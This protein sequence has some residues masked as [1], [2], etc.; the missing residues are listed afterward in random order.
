LKTISSN[1]KLRLRQL[2]WEILR[3]NSLK[4]K[5][6]VCALNAYMSVCPPRGRGLRKNMDLQFVVAEYKETIETEARESTVSRSKFFW[7]EQ[8]YRWAES[9][10]GNMLQPAEARA[11]W[12]MWLEDD[13]IKKDNLGPKKAP[14]RIAV[15][16][17]E[18]VHESA[19]SLLTRKI[20]EFKHKGVK[21]PNAAQCAQVREGVMGSHQ[22]IGGAQV[23]REAISDFMGKAMAKADGSTTSQLQKGINFGNVDVALDIKGLVEK[24]A[25]TPAATAMA[26]SA[27]HPSGNPPPTKKLKA[28][29][30]REESVSKALTAWRLSIA[31]LGKSC[32]EHIKSMSKLTADYKHI[33][34]GTSC[35]REHLI[36]KPSLL[37]LAGRLDA[38]QLVCLQGEENGSLADEDLTKAKEKLKVYLDA[39]KNPQSNLTPASAPINK[40][41]DLKVLADLE[42]IYENKFKACNFDTDIKDVKAEHKA[43]T[44]AISDLIAAAKRS[45]ADVGIAVKGQAKLRDSADTGGEHSAISSYDVYNVVADNGGVE[46]PSYQDPMGDHDAAVFDV[47]VPCVVSRC[48]FMKEPAAL[49]QRDI[50]TTHSGQ[51]KLLQSGCSTLGPL[52]P[53]V[54]VE[55]HD[56]VLR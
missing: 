7:E 17:Y 20:A 41:L 6:L 19:D 9:V 48:R 18:K 40:Y 14:T 31:E 33:S 21:N 25:E 4:G 16:N 55:V 15:P 50:T 24:E 39:F 13:T 5:K 22:E 1:L 38:M 56:L 11:N 52:D 10:D 8:Y 12:S 45:V 26:T 35:K 51:F 46:A 54:M 2:G 23:S 28:N 37:V 42:L 53:F 36:L 32:A 27:N 49:A 44:N 47:Q 43:S 3:Y 29:F 34:E 30:N